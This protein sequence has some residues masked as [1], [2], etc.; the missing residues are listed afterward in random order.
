PIARPNGL[1]TIEPGSPGYEVLASEV[2][3]RPLRGLISAEF[4]GV[5]SW[6]L[7]TI[8]PDGDDLRM[9][10][11]VGLDRELTQAYRPSFLANG[12]A[13]A[14]FL[15]VTP[16]L[17][18]PRG[19]GLRRFRAAAAPPVTLGGPQQF[20]RRFPPRPRVDFLYASA[21]PLP[22]GR[23]LVTASPASKIDYG[24]Y[25]Q[26]NAE[27]QPVLLYNQEGRFEL[28]AVA[29]VS[30]KLGPVL[31]DE[32]STV[33]KD[34]A[35]RDL[36]EAIVSEGTFRFVCDNIFFNAPVDSEI[37]NAPPV[38]ASLEIEFWMQPQ[39][40][41]A[42]GDDEAIFIASQPLSPDGRVMQEL[43]AGVPLFEVLR[44]PDGT[45]AMGRDG[46]VFH[47]AGANFGRQGSSGSCVGC[48]AGH[49]L[50]D[51]PADPAWTNLAP[52]AFVNA[53]SERV[54]GRLNLRDFRANNAIDRRTSGPSHEWAAADSDRNTEITL[55]WTTELRARELVV[56]GTRAGGGRI[57]ERSQTVNALTVTTSRDGAV[58]QSL[59]VDTL[60][61]PNGTHLSLDDDAV[62]DQL[63][64]RIA[65]EDVQGLY[66]GRSGVALAEVEV[67]AQAMTDPFFVYLRG[68]TT[69]DQ[70]VDMSDAISTLIRL[71][72][73][74][75]AA[76]CEA[77]ADVDASQSVD[78]SDAVFLLNY[79]FRSGAEPA[80]PFP[81]CGRTEVRELLC[82][83]SPCLSSDL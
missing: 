25:V 59:R 69:C 16:F 8:R 37:A 12:D 2:S 63:T 51:P 36:T 54:F 46:Q 38:G 55:G 21:E 29:G 18:Y 19:Y 73:G 43:P 27:A 39:G 82:D 61:S 60:L 75:E 70:R 76:C 77:A 41:S 50:I 24:I 83:A 56:Y 80:A 35:P 44:R 71:F 6:F 57:G 17:G 81:D 4:P 22:D 10:S 40:T 26:S 42:E 66:E 28:D 13:V 30:R 64:L 72:R 23:L 62:F 32:F 3:T 79:L 33:M 34:D 58:V 1:G 48:H 68:D 52:S 49:T 67:I 11:G 74:G 53:N 5:N 7:A 15:P 31:I 14:V 45:V 65:R 78:L 47:V 9:W 20:P